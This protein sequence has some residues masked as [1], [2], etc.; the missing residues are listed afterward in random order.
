MINR[1][2]FA[3]ILDVRTIGVKL[4]IK[5]CFVSSLIYCLLSIVTEKWVELGNGL[6]WQLEFPNLN[7][8]NNIGINLL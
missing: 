6:T 7:I 1:E 3:N 4:A 2:K 8:P 5:H